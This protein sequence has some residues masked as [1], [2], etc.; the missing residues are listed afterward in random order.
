MNTPIKND[1]ILRSS[2]LIITNAAQLDELVGLIHDE[3]FE[4]DDI[5][6]QKNLQVIQIPYRRI[7]H[8]GPRRLIKKRL[9]FKTFEVDVVRSLITVRN[10][11]DYTFKDRAKIGTYSFN[12]VTYLNNNL[13]FDCCENLQLNIKVSGISIESND[14]E[15]KGK[16][17]LTVGL[18]WSS[19]TGKV[20]D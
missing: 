8:G 7:F 18:F 10:V 4:L 11:K 9:L 2:P 12:I 5:S 15:V 14:I 17:K 20:Y 3:Y 13:Q 19:E 1:N 6:Y 16:S